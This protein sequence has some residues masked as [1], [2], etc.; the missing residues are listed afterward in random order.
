MPPALLK[1]ISTLLSGLTRA[2]PFL[3]AFKVGEKKVEAEVIENSVKEQKKGD[4]AV[5]KV[6]KSVRKKGVADHVR[7]NKI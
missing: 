2:L 7:N 1:I 5:K 4:K 3:A 6:K